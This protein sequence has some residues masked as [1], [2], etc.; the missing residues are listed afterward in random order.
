MPTG[1]CEG[2]GRTGSASKISAHMLEC[3]AWLSLPYDR[4]FDAGLSYTQWKTGGR[5]EQREEH[6]AELADREVTLR[7]MA[8]ARWATPKDILED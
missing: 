5:Q 8:D 1:R 6:K 4:Q 7:A 3:P 2:C